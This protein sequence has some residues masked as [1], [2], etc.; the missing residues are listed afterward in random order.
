MQSYPNLKAI[1]A[2]T[3]VGVVAAAQVVTDAGLIGKVN[4][5]GLA[6]PSEFKKFIDNGS[7]PGGCAVEPDRPRLL[8]R[9][10][11]P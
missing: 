11:R 6:L 2:P 3:T 10:S 1:I 8:R 5:T 4:V 7:S 9:L